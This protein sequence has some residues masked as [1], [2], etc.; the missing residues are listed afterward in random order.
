MAARFILAHDG[1]KSQ[2]TKWYA[3][4][5][6]SL[7]GQVI[8]QT[9]DLQVKKRSASKAQVF[10]SR[11][12]NVFWWKFG[13]KEMRSDFTHYSYYLC[14]SIDPPLL[15]TTQPWQI[16]VGALESRWGKNDI[17]FSSVI[18]IMFM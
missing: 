16:T 6:N 9:V 17:D 10:F 12:P 18:D 1:V 3:I 15:L 8:M 7:P 4:A 11:K 2:Q 14:P 5:E 13:N